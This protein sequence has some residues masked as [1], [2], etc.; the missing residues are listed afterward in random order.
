MYKDPLPKQMR[1]DFEKVLA[2]DYPQ[3]IDAYVR[4]L[5]EQ[6]VP[7]VEIQAAGDPALDVIYKVLLPELFEYA[8]AVAERKRSK[9]AS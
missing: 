2:M 1:E 6:G 3:L 9:L 5:S 8:A 7:L 4:K